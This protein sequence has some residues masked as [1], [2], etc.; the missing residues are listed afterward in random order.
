MKRTLSLA[1]FLGVMSSPLFSAAAAVGATEGY[2]KEIAAW[3]AER[4]ATLT[5]PD[6]WL[7]LIGLHFISPGA[8]T[9]GSAKENDVVLTAGPA[10]IGTISV[11]KDNAVTVTFAPEVSAQV[12]GRPLRAAA[13]TVGHGTTKPTLVTLGTLTFLA[14]ERGGRIA[15][16][17]KDSAAARRAHFLG[18]DYFPID[19]AWR[20]AARWVPFEQ[21][22][23]IPITNV[24]GQV[25]PESAPGKAVFEHGGKTYEL[26]PI[27]EGPGEPLFFVISDGTSGKETYGAAR[28]IYAE[29]P[30]DGKVILDFNRAENPPCAFTPFATCPLPPRENRLPFAVT[31]GEK[32]YRGG[33][34]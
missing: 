24:L 7:T 29:A 23:Q 19:P 13:L 27:D 11:A 4:V 31:A 12:D 20:I 6:G 5:K 16:R 1:L 33:H 22:R 15:L 26:L 30:K 21:A 17:V 14:I 8:N 18:L 34:D 9:F 2:A 28:F 10:R 32:N 25:S 3:R